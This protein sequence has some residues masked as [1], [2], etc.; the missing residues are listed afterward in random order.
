[1]RCAS[2]MREYLSITIPS[3][4]DLSGGIPDGAEPIAGVILRN[5]RDELHEQQLLGEQLQQKS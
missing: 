1:M 3:S 2:V 4:A 5:R